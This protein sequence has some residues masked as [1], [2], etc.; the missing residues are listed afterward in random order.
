[1][2]IWDIEPK[3]LCRLHLLAEHRELHGL[4]NILTIHKGMG[5]YS[6]HPETKR[7]IGKLKALYKRHQKLVAEMQFRG[8]KHYSLLNK[9]F[10]R[11][12]TVQS[13]FVDLP[14]KQIEI[15]KNKKCDCFKNK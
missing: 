9:T 7:W 10:A 13:D 14:C 4:W 8:Y 15:L 1:M 12:K 2:R 3:K 11:G 6:H 5:A